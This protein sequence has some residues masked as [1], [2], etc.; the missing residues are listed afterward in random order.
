MQSSLPRRIRT[1]RRFVTVAACVGGAMGAGACF[2]LDVTNP[3]GLNRQNVFNN[4]SNAE[5]AL[6]GGWRRYFN[7]A[8]GRNA[9]GNATSHHIIMPTWGNEFTTTSTG[10]A[11]TREPREPIDNTALSSPIT[12][13]TWYD[14]LGTISI[15]REVYNGIDE[16]GLRFGALT[17]AAPNGEDTPRVRIFAK[18]LIAISHYQL[19]LRFDQGFLQTVSTNID[20]LKAADLKPS[21]QVLAHTITLLR[22]VI[23]EAKAGP[24]FTIPATWINGQTITRDE[25]IRIAYSYIV[26]A[27]V[28]YPRNPAQREAVN[29]ANVLV[30]LD[31]TIT[32]DFLVKAD[33]AVSYTSSPYLANSYANSTNYRVNNRL[34]GPGDTTGRYQTWLAQPI[35]SKI[36]PSIRIVSPDRR[37]HGVNATSGRPD[38]SVA[39]RY[40]ALVTTNMTGSVGYAGSQYRGVRFLNAATDSATRAPTPLITLDEMRFI[41]AEA[42]YRLGRTSEVPALLNP[43]RVAAGLQPVT[44]SGPPAGGSCV[45]RRNDGSCG[46]LF[47]ALQYEK[48]MVMFATDAEVAYYD[49]RGW[50]KLLVGTPLELP[51]SGRD[52]TFYGLPIYTF[53]GV[54]GNGAPPGN[55]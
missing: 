47:D 55:P 19:A 41:R 7:S 21:A 36:N 5:A 10:F 53:G 25:F 15:A 23:A 51:V 49:Q 16:F 38:S 46:D 29:W 24:N 43:T 1:W 30:L 13:G 8:T 14:P 45:P 39:G 9:Y 35:A 50:G 54:A 34:I 6:I 44:A 42:L 26:R 32:K 20:T 17:D 11:Q 40:F 12:R 2:G 18:F 28:Y 37:I 48:R 27:N 22:E 33:P 31:S 3:N 52:L 4:T